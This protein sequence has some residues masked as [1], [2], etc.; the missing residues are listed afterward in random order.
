MTNEKNT[1]LYTGV[2]NDLLRRVSEHKSGMQKGF[3]SKYKCNKLVWYEHFSD[4][5][6]AIKA[7][8]KIKGGSR[9]K[10][11]NLIRKMNPEWKDLFE[12]WM[13]DYK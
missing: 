1:V 11:L 6:D 2:T 7:E 9:E 10:K 3:T 12:D 8:K 4:I 13:K 5:N